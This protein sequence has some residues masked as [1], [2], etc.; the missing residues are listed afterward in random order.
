MILQSLDAVGLEQDYKIQSIITINNLTD[1]PSPVGT[2]THTAH[3][4]R[5]TR[6]IRRFLH[7]T[8]I[9]YI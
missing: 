3:L 6:H 7:S 5:V 2:E 4:V 9:I 8:L 1:Q